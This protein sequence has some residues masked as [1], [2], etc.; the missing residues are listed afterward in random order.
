[1][2]PNEVVVTAGTRKGVFLFVGDPARED[3]RMEG[4]F[5]PGHDVNH[6]LLDG[7][8]GT[9]FATGND[10]WFGPRI[11]MSTDRGAT[12]RDAGQSPH[13]AEGDPLGS[14][15]RLWRIEPAATEGGTMWCGGDP[16]VLFRSSDGGETWTEVASLSTH[17]TRGEW[18]PGAGG[19]TAHSVVLDP[20]RAERLWIAISAAG[21][22]RSD[23]AGATWTAQNAQLKN[24]GAKYD[25]N[26]PVYTEVGQC[27]H[28]LVMGAGGR[29]YAQTHWGTYRSDHGAES[30]VDITE[31]LP[32]DFGMVMAAHPR[33]R[34]TAYVVPLVGG[35]FRVPPEGRLRVWRTR[36]GGASWQALERGLPQEGA[37]MGTYREGLAIDALEPA[38][39]YLGTNT[40]QLYASVDEGDSWRLVTGD[41]PPI[42]SVSVTV[43]E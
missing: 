31:G 14:V 37:Y 4:P 29:L 5:L 38:G 42:S 30:W 21:V 10:P 15:E 12:W 35:E 11:T 6:A 23:D 36:D 19:L 20:Q 25:A 22:F 40:G 33:E 18:G 27:V 26:I 17:E 13:L 16:G 41:L 28:H 39:L 43:L 3:W 32:S 2:S 7:R 34:D 9:L 24:V 8:S 1:M